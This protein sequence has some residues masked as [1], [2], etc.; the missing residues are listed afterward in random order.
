[1]SYKVIVW[2]NFHYMDESEKYEKGE[3][4]SYDAAVAVCKLMVDDYLVGHYRPGM[5]A[6]D[7]FDSYTSFG[8]DPSVV[9]VPEGADRFSAWTYAKKRCKE[10]C[11]AT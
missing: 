11:N 8:E 5:S 4:E 9:P 1:M 10:I 7:L 3:Y 6:E 2:D